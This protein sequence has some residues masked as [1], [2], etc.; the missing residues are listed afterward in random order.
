MLH[1]HCGELKNFDALYILVI[2]KNEKR[3]PKDLNLINYTIF[4][5]FEFFSYFISMWGRYD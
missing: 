4:S 5:H 2:I 1:D 3:L